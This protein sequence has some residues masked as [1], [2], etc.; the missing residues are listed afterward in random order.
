MNDIINSIEDIENL[1]F[2]FDIKNAMDKVSKL[3]E[4]LII[5]SG[6]LNQVSLVK[7]IDIIN[8][9]NTALVN[10]DYLLY[11]DILEYELKPFLE[12]EVNL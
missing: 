11:N 2:D 8:L 3:T 7:L 9:M 12:L 6:K 4:D 5:F 1:I 10:K